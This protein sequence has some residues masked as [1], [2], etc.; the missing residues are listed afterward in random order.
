MLKPEL[1]KL[2]S[3]RNPHLDQRDVEKIVN[4]LIDEIIAAMARG[5]RVELRGF[6]AFSVKHRPA[7]AGR[8][9][10]TGAHVPVDQKSVPFFKTGKE[11]RERLNREGGSPEAGA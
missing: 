7:R 6:G 3:V 9:P 10:R 1:V 8:N 4:V 11:M 2:I 5:D